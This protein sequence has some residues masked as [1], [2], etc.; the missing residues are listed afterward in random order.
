MRKVENFK[1]IIVLLIFCFV[2]L[3][4]MP[5]AEA[6]L[7]V[8]IEYGVDN[9]VQMGKGHPVKIEMKNNG[10]AVKGD[11]VIFTSPT[12][13]MAGSYVIP[14]E[15]ESG[16]SKVIDLS[17]KGST[18]QYSYGYNG[19]PT[20]TISFYEGGVENGKE[21][22]LSGNANAKPRFMADN[23]LI[24]GVLSNNHDAVNYMKLVKYQNEAMELLNIKQEHIPTESFG[25]EMFDVILIHDFPISTLTSAQQ[26]ALKEWVT[27]GGSIVYDSKISMAQ[28][29]GELT[30]LLL[31]DPIKETN[32]TALNSEST[33]PNLPVYTGEMKY[34]DV[35]VLVKE[36]ETPLTVLKT[37]GAGTVTQVTSSLSNAAW[38]GWDGVG[39][40]WNSI[41]QKAS[42]KNVATYKAPLLE[43]ISHQ[44]S[45]IGETF[46][47][48]IVSVPLLIGAFVLY[49]I[50]LIPV[51]YFIL[52]KTDKRE[53]AWW[54][55]PG[56]A[57][58]T[59]VAVFGI[60]AKDRIAGTQINESSILVL[61]GETKYASGFGVA[62]ILTNS[63]GKYRVETEH[64][65]T[66]FFP[67]TYGYND[68]ID[69]MKNYAYLQ[70]G[71]NGTDITF[72]DVEYWSI[73]TSVGNVNN[74]ELGA[75]DYE[76][77]VKDGK[78]VGNI[79][80]GLTYEL[81]DAYLLSGRYA[82]KLGSIKA[83]EAKQI[84]FDIPKG[85]IANVL[86]SPN[87][88]ALTNAFP[89]FSNSMYQQ[90]GPMQI[91]KSELQSYKQFQMLDMLLNRKNVFSETDQPIIVGYITQD[92]LGTKVNGKKSNNHSL[93][94]VAIP[95][96][97]NNDGS[98]SFSFSEEQFSPKIAITE[99]ES[100]N[101]F[102]NGLDYGE[103]FIHVS[104]GSYT[105]SYQLPE[106]ISKDRDSFTKL[107]LKLKTRDGNLEYFIK[108]QKTG[109]LISL[110]NKSSIT[111]EEEVKDLISNQNGIDLVIKAPVNFEEQLE[112]PGIELEG[113]LS[114]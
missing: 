83:G 8:K 31:I 104:D 45:A 39:T 63:G 99:G 87:Y 10:D 73:R 13:N 23:R 46:P 91:E 85:N 97:I 78:V 2:L 18:D 75:W 58:F 26:K 4:G 106:M 19:N 1:K 66:D 40:W 100:G 77:T 80:N 16:G 56:I 103:P 112:I 108:N 28:D 67:V 48:S 53:H 25:L 79:Q 90:G 34:D 114:Q 24:L 30:D 17:V 113:E 55:I 11:L 27:N 95:V 72:N 42:T 3:P 82:Q 60:G 9:K 110:E 64:E 43:E 69:L 57:V 109:E 50:I 71:G 76:L 51:L 59:S 98:G 38:S 22:K 15:L 5:S 89:D 70:A 93:H 33:F 52:K 36:G 44:L 107:K 32:I 74:V 12:Y 14:V 54:I 102:H 94:L 61:N 92:L 7:E 47:G 84:E 105:I 68:N 65:Q 86:A 81:Q 111:I 20:D 62:S 6:K 101:I 29:F 21:V 49:L 37:F 41:M 88:A 35:K 96:T